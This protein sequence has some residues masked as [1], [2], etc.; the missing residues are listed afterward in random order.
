MA[1]LLVL[2]GG[3]LLVACGGGS[4]MTEREF[5]VQLT[6]DYRTVDDAMSQVG[7]EPATDEAQKLHD[8]VAPLSEKWEDIKSP[9]TRTEDLRVEFVAGLSLYATAFK[10]YVNNESLSLS[11]TRDQA[12]EHLFN[13][14]T[15]IE[16]LNKELGLIVTTTTTAVTPTT[17]AP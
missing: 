12:D 15:P 3:F 1:L 6:R 2:L 14:Y 10:A 4:A 13:I 11:E 5:M 8:L 16:M 9:S 17:L 7:D